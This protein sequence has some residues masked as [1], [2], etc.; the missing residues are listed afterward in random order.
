MLRGPTLASCR[1]SV[2]AASLLP[3][4]LL[5][6]VLP[7]VDGATCDAA[8]AEAPLV[9][10]SD[11][12][13]F[14]GAF[15][16]VHDKSPRS[17][18]G[19][20]RPLAAGVETVEVFKWALDLLNRG[21]GFIPGIKIG[22]KVYDSC[23]HKAKAYHQLSGLL[24]VLQE[25]IP[26]SCVGNS[27]NI[28]GTLLSNVLHRE[29]EIARV[30]REH[31]IP[32]IPLGDDV[33]AAPELVAKVILNSAYDMRW[34]RLVIFH[35]SDE[36][37][38]AVVKYITQRVVSSDKPCILKMKTI[39]HQ[40]DSVSAEVVKTEL[41]SLVSDLEDDSAVVVI[42]DSPWT[43]AV[44]DAMAGI[45]TSAAQHQWLF[46]WIPDAEALAGIGALLSTGSG[47]YTL[48]P[49]PPSVQ[50]F[51][52]YWATLV[53]VSTTSRLEDRSYL[54]LVSDRGLCRI[55]GV[56]SQYGNSA[57]C[58]SFSLHEFRVSPLVRTSHVLPAIR[59]LLTMVHAYK[60]AWTVL[61]NGR[62]G[63]CPVLRYLPRAQFVQGFL[64]PAETF[65]TSL[66]TG[67][68]ARISDDL[69]SDLGVSHLAL[70]RLVN[71]ATGGPDF[72]QI[73]MYDGSGATLL[74]RDVTILP[75]LCSSHKCDS[76]IRFRSSRLEDSSTP[77]GPSPSVR[78]FLI[79]NP[80]DVILPILLPLHN[81][82]R[83]P[84][85][86]G[87]V[88][89]RDAVQDLEAALWMVDRINSDGY[90]L[91][92]GRLGLQVI[93]TCSSSRMLTKEV[94][95]I[96]EPL[97]GTPTVFISTASREESLAAAAILSQ[98]NI[99]LLSTKD[100]SSSLSPSSFHYQIT[101]PVEYV[102]EAM[103]QYLY[104][105]DW[106]YVS[107]LAS[108]SEQ[109]ALDSFK[110]QAHGKGVCLAHEETLTSQTDV[111]SL[112]I[113]LKELS[114]TGSRGV[115][116]WTTEEDT[117]KLLK[118]MKRAKQSG[119]LR[120]A[121]IIL[122][123]GSLE[124]LD[125]EDYEDELLG[126]VL[127]Q[128]KY[129]KVPDF[130]AY[131][132]RLKP[133][134]NK[135]DKVFSEV[136]DE[137]KEC[138][139]DCTVKFVPNHS[140][141][142]SMQAVLSAATAIRN[143]RIEVCGDYVEDYEACS[144]MLK[145]R[146]DSMVALERHVGLSTT[147][148]V[149]DKQDTFTFTKD[150][151]GNT[152]VQLLNVRRSE[153]RITL[154]KVGSFHK[155]HVTVAVPAVTH[156]H[157]GE[158]IPIS[159]LRSEC[160]ALCS[161]CQYRPLDFLLI[162]SPDNMYLAA[163]FPVHK[164][165]ETSPF[166]CSETVS[167]DGLLYIESFL[168]ALD[169]INRS[170]SV[171]PSVK[172]GAIVFDTCG[173]RE[174]TYR[175]V[176]NFVSE[177]LTSLKS[178]VKLPP[179]KQVYGFVSGG[180][181]ATVEPVADI[182]SAFDVPT[183][184]PRDQSSTLGRYSNVLQV[185][186]P[187]D[188]VAGAVFETLKYFKWSYV[189]IVY[190]EEHRDTYE[191]L[192][193]KVEQR[194]SDVR[195]S[196]AVRAE[197]PSNHAAY[198]RALG[199]LI[200][201]KKDGARV[202]VL[203]LNDRH[204]EALFAQANQTP[205]WGLTFVAVGLV[206]VLYH[207]PTQTT[208]SI[209]IVLSSSG[210]PEFKEHMQSLNY[211]NNVR[212]PWFRSYLEQKTG[213]HG[214]DS[215]L[216][217]PPTHITADTVSVPSTVTSVYA[218]ASGID[219]ARR[220]ACRGTHCP[221]ADELREQVLNLTRSVHITRYDKSVFAFEGNHGN[222]KLDVVYVQ[223]G[224]ES[225]MATL[226]IGFYT[227]KH[228][229]HI[230]TSI[231]ADTFHQKLYSV[232]STCV[233][234]PDCIPST[235][236]QAPV[237]DDSSVQ[238]M[239]SNDPAFTIGAMLPVHKRGK[240]MFT[241]G[242]FE[243]NATF[244]KLAA[245]AYAVNEVNSN[246][247]FP[248]LQVN[249]IVFDYCGTKQRAEEKLY[250]YFSSPNAMSLGMPKSMVS[251]LTFDREVAT[252][253]EPI[254]K[255]SDIPVV[256]TATKTKFGDTSLDVKL[257][258][259]PPVN[260]QVTAL[261]GLLKHYDWTH[262]YVLYTSDDFGS[263]AYFEVTKLLDRTGICIA[264]A[265]TIGMDASD[266]DVL[267]SVMKL[268]DADVKVTLVLAEDKASVEKIMRAARK[269]SFLERFVW[270]GAEGFG[271]N[272]A[273]L[274]VIEG[275]DVDVFALKLEN[276]KLHSF[277]DFVSQLTLGRHD[278]I[279]DA[280]F[281][282]FWQNRFRCYLPN[283]DF[284]QTRFD[285]ACT[286]TE[287]LSDMVQDRYA[288]HTVE[289]VK[290]IASALKSHISRNCPHDAALLS[291]VEGCG[292][293]GAR[294]KLKHEISMALLNIDTEGCTEC[295]P[296]RL[297]TFGYQ[298]LK[299]NGTNAR[300][301]IYEKVGYFKNGK[302]RLDEEAIEFT[303]GVAPMSTCTR[304][305]E[306]RC[307]RATSAATGQNYFR[308]HRESLTANFKTVWGIVVTALSLLGIILVVICALYFLMAF[309]VAVGT[310]ILGYMILFGLLALYAV[311]FAFLVGATE[312]SCGIRRFLMG[313]AYSI[314]F[315]GMLVKVLNTW[316]L[317]GYHGNSRM[318]HDGTQLS[319]PTGLLLIACGL[320]VI[321]VVLTTAWLILMPP[322]IGFYEHVWRCAPPA[323]F[324]DELVVSMV[325]VM[326]LLAVT[327]LFSVLTAPC[328]ENN[329]ESRWILACCIFVS[330]AWLVWTVLSTQLPLQ[331][332]DATIAVANLVCATLVMLCLYLRKVYL[333][334]KL[335]RQARD[336]E[337]KAKLQPRVQYPQS[338][339][340]TLHKGTP[341]VPV[342]YGSQASL[343]S[344]KL[345]GQFSRLSMDDVASDGSGSVQVQGTDLY[346]LEM[347]DGG[348]QFQPPSSLYGSMMMLDDNVAYA[349]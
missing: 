175:D 61:C 88:V 58:P 109:R 210:V 315:S 136:W 65:N 151:H 99:T 7:A 215:C 292:G 126:A 230:N 6:S 74:D 38:L 200:R 268:I 113:K 167:D 66:M 202:V 249:A 47:V 191:Q 349:R 107:V 302:M 338:V 82:G 143:L 157:H 64:E 276:K 36:H 44:V 130:A 224:I 317:M 69:L 24:P 39:P 295:Q 106:R 55:A 63:L 262:V 155:G 170:P 59:G 228:G 180:Q 165:G 300:S 67:R 298:L 91:P 1:R 345:N 264:G 78:N 11:A 256:L 160:T 131:F 68:R 123:H 340:G 216:K 172:L 322:R 49:Y 257:Q 45:V 312:T 237:P 14:L 154:Q 320:V 20:G 212:N 179:M 166:I 174:K 134:E 13:V 101:P 261:L 325:Y 124:P 275:A 229:L 153:T 236:D 188:V 34:E 80:K 303:T 297:T 186:L 150:R 41:E 93:D 278:P 51:E 50:S 37:S 145:M 100:I 71:D 310:T 316:R 178:H 85:T 4:I 31:H 266:D 156:G 181:T 121:D 252:E 219:Q 344:K 330:I 43:K 269:A 321:Q 102:V 289:T 299:L 111:D 258:T 259:M 119:K 173:S 22:V 8:H 242:N 115:V 281:E 205:S 343:T 141:V 308:Q 53:D 279:P 232:K 213:C 294:S 147:L 177:S 194:E 346:P 265:E 203:L 336:Q 234:G 193:H 342:F 235:D 52:E 285:T 324:E 35:S 290:M 319:S 341:V 250:H 220:V 89:N 128:P 227:K 225:N 238:I 110:K 211:R 129:G 163:T 255:S 293:E 29:E 190:D 199:Q 5:G 277:M 326:L 79:G 192:K 182:M 135:R 318:H 239:S 270:V 17:L 76:C 240:D 221:D 223:D 70:T 246:S 169:Q 334:N 142:D 217:V 108:E 218:L 94:S 329:G 86:C 26:Q 21:E 120:P 77:S 95:A 140:V 171:L 306:E 323:S 72:K 284:V 333:Y 241:C 307:P 83:E 263:D 267:H 176:S 248:A 251:M 206:D 347:Y 280:W 54:E 117:L 286:G 243:D 114:S 56:K 12:D 204:A 231:P 48:A 9:L 168:W 328:R 75:V 32:N 311:N 148:R 19:C 137:Y 164:H 233:S 187:N 283:S 3:V 92:G 159:E 313:L 304:D 15:L 184:V 222:G 260:W 112:I 139:N 132:E 335:S 158:E 2:L 28:I 103:A 339:Y 337:M 16:E 189:S 201:K 96:L 81:E 161:H 18:M 195:F 90:I 272:A 144:E 125:F 331:Y 57:P 30:L 274:E 25:G 33:V 122:L 226:P 118:A 60:S 105:L 183:L 127:L 273:L 138:S 42:G 209:S 245:L 98:L 305:C 291:N 247:T 73:I 146:R 348:S 314:I 149:G 244:Q 214:A 62:K 253:I 97:H 27:S 40:G 296:S 198:A 332:R 116:L 327:I 207:Y 288:Y 254:L 282:E 197:K 185:S 309:P 10:N 287:R 196:I 271:E 301:Y 46:S 23:G 208:S 162:P 84:Y 87:T 152:S 104:Y 133:W